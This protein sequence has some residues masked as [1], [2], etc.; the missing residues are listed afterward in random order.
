VVFYIDIVNILQ[1]KH[2]NNIMLHKSSIKS[3]VKK[4]FNDIQIVKIDKFSFGIFSVK[5]HRKTNKGIKIGTLMG[6]T[7]FDKF[8]NGI[9]LESSITWLGTMPL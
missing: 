4:Q 8:E 6:K 9:D 5:I 1:N 2:K 3:E 7:N